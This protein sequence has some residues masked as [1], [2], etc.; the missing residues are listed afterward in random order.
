MPFLKIKQ[1]EKILNWAGK[2]HNAHDK[3]IKKA[4][5]KVFL[6][7]IKMHHTTMKWH[8]KKAKKIYNWISI[9]QRIS[10]GCIIIDFTWMLENLDLIPNY[11]KYLLGK[12][13]RIGLEH[14][15]VWPNTQQPKYTFCIRN[16]IS[17]KKDICIISNESIRK[18]D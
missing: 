18:L 17:S 9:D 2:I 4:A 6:K 5:A 12:K 13:F 3:I 16:K 11:Q 1:M 15:R 14:C 8:H 10:T 7:H